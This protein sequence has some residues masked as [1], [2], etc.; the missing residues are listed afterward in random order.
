MREPGRMTGLNWMQRYAATEL[1]ELTDAGLM[2]RREALGWLAK[3]CGSSAAAVA[4]LGACSSADS[5]AKPPASSGSGSSTSSSTASSAPAGITPPTDGEPG[6]VL[7][8]A[9]DDPAI[10]ERAVEFAGPAS[11]MF[12]SFAEPAAASADSVPGIIVIHEIF[13]LND[14][15][16]DVARRLAKVGYLALAPDLASRAGGTDRTPNVIGAL[17]GGPIEDRIADLGAAARFLE[18]V[19]AYNG[20][21]GVVGFC[22]GG[23]MSL[24]YAAAEPTVTAAVSYYGPTPE[25]ASV[26]R[27]SKAAVLAHYGADDA[28]VNAGIGALESALAGRTFSTRVWPGVGHQFNNDTS[29]AYREETA[30][31][32]WTETL[33]WFDRHLR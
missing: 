20:T 3:V 15:I 5:R 19:D 33:G 23:A 27:G 17:T 12:G 4:F 11:P 29:P 30:V 13:G 14:H 28:R 9:K 31:A 18:G 16:R 6:H 24:S 2:D 22:F 8:V 32:A 25:P 1:V 7:S 26:M 21:L 10:R